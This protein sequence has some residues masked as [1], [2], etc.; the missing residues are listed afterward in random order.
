MTNLNKIAF[1]FISSFQVRVGCLKGGDGFS[2]IAQ[3]R[4]KRGPEPIAALP[5]DS[6]KSSLMVLHVCVI[7]KE[8]S[9]QNL[10]SH[11]SI[12]PPP[13]SW[14]GKGYP[15][16]AGFRTRYPSTRFSEFLHQAIATG[17]IQSLLASLPFGIAQ[18]DWSEVFHQSKEWFVRWFNKWTDG[19]P[20]ELFSKRK[21]SALENEHQFV[22]EYQ[23]LEMTLSGGFPE[24]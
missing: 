8:D 7:A 23:F 24:K 18:A 21:K 20:S 9:Q 19:L 22:P 10:S 12:F 14:A 1:F 4:E 13:S 3:D 16:A 17:A 6:S 2:A 11:E 15:R 5:S